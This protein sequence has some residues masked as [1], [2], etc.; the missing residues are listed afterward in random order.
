VQQSRHLQADGRERLRPLTLV[1]LALA[2]C[3]STSAP[4]RPAP[5]TIRAAVIGG[6]M[7]T[8]FWPQLV[9]R[10]SAQT[11]HTVELA[12]TGPKPEVVSAFKKG[13]VDL[14]VVHASDA[15]INLVAD[16]YARD[17]QPWVR[18]DMV[19]V[20]PKEDP[21]G[22]KGGRDAIAALKKIIATK[23]RML[24]H[25]SLGA[26]G[27]LHDLM[28]EGKLHFEDE[29]IAFFNAENQRAVLQAAAAD[30]AYTMVGRIPV[31]TGKLRADGMEIMVRGDPRMRRPYLVETSPY[32][33]DATRELARWLRSK[34][35]Q[36]FIATFGLGKYDDLP[37]FYPVSID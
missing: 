7:D 1:A 25:A 32:A 34:A 23:S 22:I 2:A 19:I 12:A 6:M 33:N 11:G 17:P 36:D 27:V 31:L 29:N 16:G 37:L 13:G 30:K 24:V 18:N 3:G 15:M 26:D 4:P 14:I 9:Q 21:A 20:G 28:E 10:F 35:A 5:Q 8:Q